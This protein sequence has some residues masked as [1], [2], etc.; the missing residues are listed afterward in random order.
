MFY[1]LF[2]LENNMVTSTYFAVFNECPG[3]NECPPRMSAPSE[4]WEIKWVPRYS[5]R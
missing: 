5:F 4:R 3:L 1:I 2:S